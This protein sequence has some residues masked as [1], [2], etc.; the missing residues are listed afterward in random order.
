MLTKAGKTFLIL[1]AVSGIA[2]VLLGYRTLLAL[3]LGLA[4]AVAVGRLWI[5]RR[6]RVD[7]QRVVLPE[8]VRVGR[9]A[10][11]NLTIRN[12]GRRRT[13]GGVALERFGAT[14]L[15]V[16]VPSLEPGE[17]IT[18]E[19]A[20]P[21]D[22]RGVF[23]VGPLDVTRADP[24]GLV[25]SGE[26]EEGVTNL[27]VH[28]LTHPLEPF[29]SGIARDLEG[30]ESG[31]ALEGGVTFHTL[32]DYVRGDDL[33]QI[34]WRSSARAGKLMVRHNVDTHQPRS[35]VI[36]DTRA[37]SHSAE[38]FEDAIRAAASIVT[39]SM[40]RGFDFRVLTT[41]G[42]EMN[43]MMPPVTIMD[44]FA[45]LGLSINGSIEETLESVQS[46]LGG[47]SLA[48]VTGVVSRSELGKLRQFRD[49]FEVITVAQFT[50]GATSWPRNSPDAT[51]LASAT[52][53]EFA[54][55]WNQVTRVG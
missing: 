18:V 31:E 32:R 8:R 17:S 35:L 2:G 39:A 27:W 10:R 4:V 1:G 5:V 49:R 54:R 15:P 28:P 23:R 22:Q 21:T 26:P 7:A 30:P 43:Q 34:H 29:P 55:A 9:P 51:V 20:L 33:R 52:S 12:T 6:P 42:L 19:T 24:F 40:V 41:D 47:V 45:D 46:D 38:S 48:L 36:L 14:S 13:S 50:S 53:R 44:R 25:R 37:T 11:S 16:E 3:G